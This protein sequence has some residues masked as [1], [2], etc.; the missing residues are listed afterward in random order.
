MKCDKNACKNTTCNIYDTD[1][2]GRC[3]EYNIGLKPEEPLEPKPAEV[4]STTSVQDKVSVTVAS[5]SASETTHAATTT[6]QTA[7]SPAERP[8]ELEAVLSS[9]VTEKNVAPIPPTDKVDKSSPQ[10]K[11]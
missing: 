5:T 3:R 6:T 8:L 10:N 9:T 4:G 2:N 1:V 7:T 11:V